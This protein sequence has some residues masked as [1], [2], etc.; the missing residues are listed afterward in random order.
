MRLLAL[1]A[2]VAAIAVSAAAPAA[3]TGAGPAQ[4]HAAA[5]QPA[6]AIT[7]VNPPIGTPGG[8]VTVSGTVT[9]PTGATAS[10]LSVQ[11][12]SS[13]QHLDGRAA[14]D[15]YLTAQGPTG[16]D[17]ATPAMLP[18]LPALPAHTSRP[19]SLTLRMSQAGMTSFGVYPLAAQLSQN[20]A[21]L[22]SDRTFLPFW[23]GKSELKTL[24]PL[25]VG[26]VWPLI[27]TPHQAACGALLNNDLAATLASG[28][29]LN[30]LL[31]V[32]TTPLARRARLTWAIDPALL[33]DA[34]VMTAP[35][36]VGRSATC[37][38]G[39]VHPASATARAFLAGVQSKV[40]RQD[41]F[42]TP[43]ADVDVA[44]LA[45]RGLDIELGNALTDGRSL[46]HRILGQVQ[47]TSGDP[48]DGRSPNPTGL[49]AWPADGVA[50]YG[51]L[52][53]LAAHQV[54]TVILD[55]SMMRP[56]GNV[57]YTP[58]AVTSTP[59]GLLGAQLH[60]L[61]ADSD[62]EHVLAVPRG[63]V[64]GTGPGGSPA[65][66]SAAQ[67]FAREQW[68]LA[69]TAVIAAEAPPTA[70]AV[71]VAPPRRWDP[72]AGLA[73]ALL[74]ETVNTPWLQPAS[75]ASI[76]AQRPAPG[77]SVPR[78]APRTHQVRPNELNASLLRQV[79]QLGAQIR[80]LAS[81]FVRPDPR[82]LSK[83]MATVE[84]SAWRGGRDGRRTAQQL[85]R[86]VTAYVAAQQKKIHIVDPGRLTLGGK[87]GEVPVSISNNIGRAIQ[88][89]LAVRVPS[90]DRVV[91]GNPSKPVTV[92]SGT[93]KTIKIPVRA[94]AAGSTTLTLTLTT[95]DGKPL[96]GTTT[97]LTV[98][99]T[100]FGTMAIVIIGV[101]LGVFVLTAAA[102][103]IRSGRGQPKEDGEE[104]GEADE[105]GDAGLT[106]PDP[107][108]EAARADTVE[109]ERGG[110][111]HPAKE[112]DDH[113][114]IPRRAERR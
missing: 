95:L 94:A 64:P 110:Q 100:H 105:T 37:A 15:S 26:W 30:E 63:R 74:T 104:Y 18:A 85:L 91:I 39:S 19:W 32:G 52:E 41:F 103:A 11:L 102:R 75:L 112:P 48:G 113:A 49:I 86:R 73:R 40:A 92:A 47:R 98:E 96:R 78:Q 5:E 57:P 61:L 109:P 34:K 17:S 59:D 43:Y 8:T 12:W 9:N 22:A 1:A 97:S 21:P 45:H 79:R 67:A 106:E 6:I 55:S 23:P 53:T 28:G 33:N 10:G 50:D 68:F 7:S 70:R 66:S 51:V 93:Q 2:G 56:K 114:S 111:S 31:S 4:P 71:V 99:A 35:Y 80:L 20:L 46:A 3:A 25:S 36:R 88:V 90:S 108:Y 77:A 81:V 44:A 58:T 87:S 13:S 62:I 101:A 69:E 60:V 72:S 83:A 65:A 84:S 29:R 16:V 54:G 24:K 89:R 76:V 107:A 42:V 82:Y 38:G 14:M 27:D